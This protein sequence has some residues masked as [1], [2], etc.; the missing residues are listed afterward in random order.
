MPDINSKAS[1]QLNLFQILNLGK[2]SCQHLCRAIPYSQS[3]SASSEKRI[4]PGYAATPFPG[5][6][7]DAHLRSRAA[8]RAAAPVFI[9]SCSVMPLPPSGSARARRLPAG[10][11]SRCRRRRTGPRSRRPSG[12]RSPRH[13]GLRLASPRAAS[14][15]AGACGR[16][17]RGDCAIEIRKTG[18][19]GADG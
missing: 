10:R 13:S 1:L 18:R 2:R 9:V 11:S 14:S 3:R 5:Q 12:Q 7:A 4:R 8:L 17:G 16:A 6:A 15:A 19:P